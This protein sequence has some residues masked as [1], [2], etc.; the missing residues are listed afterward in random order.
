MNENNV[1]SDAA[2]QEDTYISMRTLPRRVHLLK[3]K[4][5]DAFSKTIY[6]H[7][8]KL[9]AEQN[10]ERDRKRLYKLI[11]ARLH[12]R[13]NRFCLPKYYMPCELNG[14]ILVKR[15]AQPADCGGKKRKKR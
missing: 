11:P 14:K 4:G 5:L 10:R 1:K 2:E 9:L 8:R 12:S 13:E 7:I 15:G 6:E 3:E